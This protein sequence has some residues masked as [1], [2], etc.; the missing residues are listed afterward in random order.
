MDTTKWLICPVCS[1]KTR[2]KLRE[3]TVLENFPL[4]CPRCKRETLI[5][6]RQ[7][8]VTVIYKS[9]EQTQNR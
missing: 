5:S 4:F 7:F 3:D 2:E 9:D 1:S 6:A 8:I